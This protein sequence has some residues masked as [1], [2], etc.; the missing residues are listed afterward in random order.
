MF[1]ITLTTLIHL[2]K[3]FRSCKLLKDSLAEK[4][5]QRWRGAHRREWMMKLMTAIITSSREKIRLTLATEA[6]PL[7]TREVYFIVISSFHYLFT[8]LII[9]L[10]FVSSSTVQKMKRDA[11]KLY[12][13]RDYGSALRLCTFLIGN[14]YKFFNWVWNNLV[15]INLCF[16]L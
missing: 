15:T 3:L 8:L 5:T 9:Q 2:W 11:K 7:T 1:L 12:K 13:Q 4:N 14:V 16:S 10:Y 6:I